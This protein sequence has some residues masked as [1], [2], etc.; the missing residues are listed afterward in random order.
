M[1][2]ISR[3]GVSR[4]M[5]SSGVEGEL[6]ARPHAYAGC[7][8][9]ASRIHAVVT[10]GIENP[11]LISRWR[12]NPELL[13]RQGIEPSMVDL[14][15][16]WKFAGLTV[17]VRHNALRDELPAS[18]RLLTLL[19]LEIDLFTA[20]AIDTASR[21]ARFAPTTEGRTLDLLVFLE[22]WL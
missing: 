12:A 4:R 5:A 18:F 6:V 20:Y 19:G 1:P 13:R 15:A 14:D 9:I 3:Q 17:K 10:A 22:G 11:S 7:C 2:S 8:M 16:L 21:G